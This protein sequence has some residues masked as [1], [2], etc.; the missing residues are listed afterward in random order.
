[1]LEEFV[2]LFGITGPRA[3]SVE[4]RYTQSS[5]IAKYDGALRGCEDFQD[6]FALV[7]QC[8]RTYLGR[9]RD[10]MVLQ[11]V[12]MPLNVGAAHPV[13]TN[14]I[15]MNKALLDLAV[16]NRS[17]SEVKAF[18]FSI[19]LHEYIHSLGYLNE[20][21]TRELVFLVTQEAFGPDHLVTHV[22]RYGPWSIFGRLQSHRRSPN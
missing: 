20:H 9:E 11:L 1:V 16:Q 12:E 18:V 15:V 19:L 6:I 22:A 2:R 8:T 21:E 10:D 7:K 14:K 17:F 13:G 3:T 4:D 5:T